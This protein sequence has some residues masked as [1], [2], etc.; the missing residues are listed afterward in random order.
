MKKYFILSIAL[1][2]FALK[3]YAFY[4]N[5]KVNFV[6]TAIKINKI[7]FYQNM[8]WWESKSSL[9]ESNRFYIIFNP[10]GKV[11]IKWPDPCNEKNL[12]FICAYS[13]SVTPRQFKRLSNYLYKNNFLELKD[14]YKENREEEVDNEKGYTIYYIDYNNN[15]VK[16]IKDYRLDVPELKSLGNKIIRLKKK[17]K[18]SPVENK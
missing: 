11:L 16:I 3:S 10:D 1:F 6:D 12:N 2:F 13:G 5:G 9:L 17:I 14:Q 4:R 8:G 18:W 15:Q 7:R